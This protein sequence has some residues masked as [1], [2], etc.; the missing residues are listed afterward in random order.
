MT[1]GAG[2]DARSYPCDTRLTFSPSR[3]WGVELETFKP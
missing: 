3:L 1:R 2:C